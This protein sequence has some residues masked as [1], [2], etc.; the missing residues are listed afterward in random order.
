MLG[1]AC[2]P[3]VA[4]LPEA[5]DA[6]VVAIPAAGVAGRHRPGGR[7]RLRRRG[8]VQRRLRRGGV[9]A[10]ATTRAGRRGAPPRAAGVRPQLQRDRLARHSRT[11]LWGDAFVGARARRGGAGLPER[12]R[13]RQR[14]GHAAR[15]AL[16]HR[17]RQR[18]PG[19]PAGRRLPRRTWPA[20][21]GRRARS[22]CTWRTTAA[23][24]CATGWPRAPSRRP[25]RGAEGRALRGRRAGGRR[26]QRRAGRRPARVPQPGRG[27]GR[28]VGRRRA[29]PARAGQDA[30]RPRSSAPR[31][32][33]ARGSRS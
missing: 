15:A 23:R 1:R 7:A 4:D 24:G 30:R 27:G 5:V 12:Q 14:A 3:T 21:D 10:R 11:A 26:P 22:R 18:Q 25:G 20:R 19:G 9:R 28:G 16:P 6:V 31:P 33:G 8:R 32:T 2:V 17:G 13:R 29:R